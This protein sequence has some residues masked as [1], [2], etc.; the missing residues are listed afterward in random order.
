MKHNILQVVLTT[1]LVLSC[2]LG[3]KAQ[4]ANFQ[5]QIQALEWRC[6]GPHVG[7]RGAAVALHPTD[8]NL[9]YHGHSSGGVWKS[10]DAGNFWEPITDGQLNVGS[11]GAMALAPSNPDTIY[12]GTGEPQLRDCVSWGD[13]MYKSIDAGKTWTHIGL[14]KSM[15]ISRVRVHPSNPDLVYVSVI[16]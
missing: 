13:G 12:V 10:D 5:K 7:N 15:N 2:S 14:K 3:S 16:G 6:I 8:K 1:I 4:D 9:F 11:I